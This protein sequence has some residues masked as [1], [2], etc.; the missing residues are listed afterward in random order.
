M[1]NLDNNEHIGERPVTPPVGSVSMNYNSRGTPPPLPNRLVIV[2]LNVAGLKPSKAAPDGWDP[3]PAFHKELLKYKPHIICL[4]EV[5]SDS[6]EQDHSLFV[7]PGYECVGSRS[8]HCENVVLMVLKEWASHV[9]CT[10][11]IHAPAVL[12]TMEFSVVSGGT[13]K[14]TFGSCHLAPFQEAKGKRFNQMKI[15]LEKIQQTNSDTMI[16]AGDYNMRQEEDAKVEKDLNLRDA[17][18]E[19]GSPQDQQYTWDS[20]DRTPKGAPP[21]SGP[22]NQYHG[23]DTYQYTSRYDRVYFRG[24]HILQRVT[25]FQLI[26]NNPLADDNP[27]HYLSDHYGIVTTFEVFK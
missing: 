24:D 22:H 6:T 15:I 10:S 12:G 5:P 7:L 8:S 25:N 19:A 16:L 13:Q 1:S 20:C 26:A 23:P 14:I 9:V 3:I 18:K 17:W 21:G 2:S 11:N 4:Q 27:F